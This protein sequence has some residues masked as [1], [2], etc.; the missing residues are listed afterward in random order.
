M[1]HVENS[2]YL[3]IVLNIS[4]SFGWSKRRVPQSRSGRVFKGRGNFVSF[5]HKGQA[6]QYVSIFGLFQRYR[7]PS[8]SRSRSRSVTPPHWRIAQKRTIKMTDLEVC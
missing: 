8:R 6:A 4:S 1:V 5:K 7:T 2:L 3:F